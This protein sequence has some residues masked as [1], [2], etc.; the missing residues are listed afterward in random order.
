MET[1][2]KL[3]DVFSKQIYGA[4]VLFFNLEVWSNSVLENISSNVKVS[5]LL[6]FT[7]GAGQTCE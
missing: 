6:T 7:V 5:T 3:P 4:T 2:W 1:S